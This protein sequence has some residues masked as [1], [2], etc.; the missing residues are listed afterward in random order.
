M[1]RSLLA[2]SAACIA[3]SSMAA[4]ADLT[5]QVN[6]LQFDKTKK[7]GGEP[8]KDLCLP[9]PAKGDLKKAPAKLGRPEDVITE[10]VGRQQNI[11]I[12]GSGFYMLYGQS[13]QYYGDQNVASH[14]IYGEGND[15][16]IYNLLPLTNYDTYVK[17][18][19][20]D[21][22]ITIELP[23]TVY[24][25]DDWGEGVNLAMLKW[26]TI[27]YEGEWVD[28][29]VY[30]YDVKSVVFNIEEDGTMRADIEPD[31]LL[32]LAFTTDDWYAS[33]GA[34][35]L[36]ITDFNE[37][38]TELPAGFGVVD[39]WYWY[40][41]GEYGYP[42]GWAPSD[43]EMWFRGLSDRLPDS[44]IKATASP[45]DPFTY[46]IAQDQYIGIYGGWY[47]WTKCAKMEFDE[48]GRVTDATL[49]PE[50]YEYEIVW[51]VASDTYL[52][53]D[54]DVYLI[55]NASK[56]EVWYLD[57]FKNFILTHPAFEGTPKDPYSV[58]YFLM[59]EL[60]GYN[61]LQAI[62][63][64]VSTEGKL[65]NPDELYYVVYIDGEPWTFEPEEYG[66]DEP[67][68][69]IPWTLNNFNITIPVEDGLDAVRDISI[70]VEGFSTI[71][72]QSV[73]K[74]NGV[75]TRSNIIYFNFEDDAVETID[76]DKKV[77][78]VK[79]YDLAGREVAKPATGIF[80]KRVTFEDGTVSTFKTVL[81]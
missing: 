39:D 19:K 55:I 15:V 80:V 47:M 48:N 2:F 7:G 63:P 32:G 73:Y 74:H 57:L 26:N 76:A 34:L 1:K 28:Y 25:S 4:S 53:K 68:E 65:L 6:P 59:M 67:M 66:I 70:F 45:D 42:V 35:E 61:V 56:D 14:M 29:W 5:S 13:Y 11:T 3:L 64:S 30:D 22:K 54:S 44:W 79:Y 77:A 78:N 16:Y 69:E 41:T 51:D 38:M 10:A 50:D 24:Y 58:T 27:E 31:H 20:E 21:D 33:Y 36:S 23:Q 43:G 8:V 37:V 75:E 52:P 40:N 9:R 49:M 12:N 71:G 18:T 72:I 60:I 62:I 81:R 17:G 46:R